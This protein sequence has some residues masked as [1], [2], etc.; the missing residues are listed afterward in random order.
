MH[1]RILS[2]IAVSCAVLAA[3]DEKKTETPAAT[4]PAPAQ[5]AAP[6]TAPAAGAPAGAPAAG[7]PAAGAPAAGAAAAAG[8]KGDVKGS[9]KLTGAAPAMAELKRATDPFC[10]KTKMKD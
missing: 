1:R 9:V 8:A 2:V 7:A 3:C 10:G 5:P 6:P 4:P